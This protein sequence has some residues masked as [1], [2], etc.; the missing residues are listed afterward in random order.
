M[1]VV[2]TQSFIDS[3]RRIHGNKYDYSKT[4]Y[5]HSQLKVTI[6]C[7]SHGEFKVI[8]HSHTIQ[9]SGCIKC[10]R[11]KLKE[12]KLSPEQLRLNSIRNAVKWNKNNKERVAAIQKAYYIRNRDKRLNWQIKY[13]KRKR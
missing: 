3:A 10:Y 1:K 12:R 13:E 9:K 11:K 5:V 8:P 2:T 4:A 7:P 6:I